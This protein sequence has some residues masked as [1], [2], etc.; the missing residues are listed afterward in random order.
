[1][2]KSQ[3]WQRLKATKRIS[4][5]KKTIFHRTIFKVNGFVNE[6]V[7]DNY[8]SGLEIFRNTCWTIEI[9]SF[10]WFQFCENSWP[11]LRDEYFML[12]TL[13]T[14]LFFSPQSFHAELHQYKYHVELFNQLTQ[15]LIAVYPSDDTSRIKRMT[16]TVNM[17]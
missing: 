4:L 8:A 5:W 11:S 9:F 6:L 16:E 1:M 17:R 10:K 14:F 2:E 13:I 12:F 7:N 15:K 3:T